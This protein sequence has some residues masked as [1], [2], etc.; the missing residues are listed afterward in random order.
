MFSTG[1]MKPRL[2]WPLSRLRMISPVEPLWICSWMSG[3]FRA[4]FDR[5]AGS[6][7]I[8]AG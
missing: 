6:T 7:P 4:I 5:N 8:V 3:Y 1:R 2:I